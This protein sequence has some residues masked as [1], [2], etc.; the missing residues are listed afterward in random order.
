MKNGMPLMTAGGLIA[1]SQACCCENP[2][3]PVCYCPSFCSYF[4]EVLQPA[5]LAVKHSPVTCDVGGINQN[6]SVGPVSDWLVGEAP[7]PAG[8]PATAA[9][10]PTPI[11]SGGVSNITASAFMN[12]AV[13]SSV[14]YGP[15]LSRVAQVYVEA[16]VLVGCDDTYLPIIEVFVRATASVEDGYHTIFKNASL[17]P[18]VDCVAGSGTDRVCGD[19]RLS[20]YNFMRTP[21]TIDVTGT[22]CSIG[23]YSTSEVS[24]GPSA[25]L[26]K[27]WCEDILDNLSA[28][29]RITSRDNCLPPVACDCNVPLGGLAIESLTIG[30]WNLGDD[31]DNGCGTYQLQ[32][33]NQFAIRVDDGQPDGGGGCL[34]TESIRQ[35]DIYCQSV[36][37]VP[38]WFALIRNTCL[39][40]NAGAIT[41]QATDTWLGKFL[42]YQQECDDTENGRFAGDSIP[43]G[44]PVDIEYLGREVGFGLQECTPP[45]LFDFR[46]VQDAVVC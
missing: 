23:P 27:T 38:T 31:F 43:Q 4:I 32:S 46:L 5:P 20:G 1:G 2:P 35:L 7:P 24:A 45:G 3:P 29:F 37:G 22:T 11:S 33:G 15:T 44:E 10:G 19:G 26:N 17:R 34:P 13:L 12:A 39:Q 25:A 8:H 36:D 6:A 21:I 14:Y 9:S 18:P 42:C 30:R 28:T 16:L 41:H 40:R